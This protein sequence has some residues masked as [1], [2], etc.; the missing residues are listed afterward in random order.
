MTTYLIILSIQFFLLITIVK[1]WKV[2]SKKIKGLQD[3]KGVQVIHDT[4]LNV[5]RLGGLAIYL[6]LLFLLLINNYLDEEDK[7]FNF[8]MLSLTPLIIFAIKEDIFQNVNHFVRLASIVI[9]AVIFMW[10]FNQELPSIEIPYIYEFIN[11]TPVLF[12]LFTVAIA[13][14]VNGMNIIDGSNGITGF[15][16]IAILLVLISIG[17]TYNLYTVIELGSLLIF[18]ILIFLVFN[19]PLGKIFLG[20]SGAYLLGFFI[21]ILTIYTYSSISTLPAWGAV[22]MLFYPSIETIFSFIR[23]IMKSVSPFQ[24]D[25][26]HLHLQ[27]YN[28]ASK[29]MKSKRNANNIVALILLPLWLIPPYLSKIYINDIQSIVLSLG[30]LVVFY[31]ISFLI[32]SKINNQNEYK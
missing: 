27:I 8:I 17:S 22:L 25:R 12:V 19:Y 5:P 6:T 7:L 21:A 32:V 29:K 4:A 1:S 11:Q 16:S 20:D 24:P 10:L 14:F 15:T 30:G 3:Y 23:K 28:I 13:G 2:V 9:S 31:L 18:T 26:Y